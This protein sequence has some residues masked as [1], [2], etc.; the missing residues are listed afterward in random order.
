VK[1]KIDEKDLENFLVENQDHHGLWGSDDI[2]L[3]Q[4]RLN[5][6]GICDILTID[7]I[8]YPIENEEGCFS[9]I[10][11]VYELKINLLCVDDHIQL[12]RYVAYLKSYLDKFYDKI[13]GDLKV[14]YRVT[15]SLL[16]PGPSIA[17][18]LYYLMDAYPNHSLDII[19]YS[20]DAKAG[21]AFTNFEANGL[22][23]EEGD[24]DQAEFLGRRLN[25]AICD[26]G[27]PI[28]PVPEESPKEVKENLH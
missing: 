10:F 20:L 9:I 3:Q 24:F 25:E 7:V 6:A 23:V 17:T 16:G 1:I 19:T 15:G 8:D 22:K 11:N 14:D 27:L 13:F 4:F 26:K 12:A 21:I 2:V 28:E 18:N 5:G